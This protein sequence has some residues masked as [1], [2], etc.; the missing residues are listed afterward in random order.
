MAAHLKTV[1]L[2]ILEVSG[3]Y[4][5]RALW[6]FKVWSICS[7]LTLVGPQQGLGQA[8]PPPFVSDSGFNEL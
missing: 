7:V 8:L 2:L 4:R 5:V 6:E 1:E 3:P